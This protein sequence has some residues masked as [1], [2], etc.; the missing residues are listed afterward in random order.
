M[1]EIKAVYVG[2]LDHSCYQG[3]LVF[4]LYPVVTMNVRVLDEDLVID[5]YRIPKKVCCVQFSSLV[6]VSLTTAPGTATPPFPVL[7]STS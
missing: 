1:L 2:R 4:R 3:Y 5:G 7:P 6:A